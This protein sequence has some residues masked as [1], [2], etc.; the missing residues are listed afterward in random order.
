MAQAQG[1][2]DAQH[3]ATD[4]TQAQKETRMTKDEI[5]AT[6]G[7]VVLET[8]TVESLLDVILTYVLQDGTPLNYE[9]IAEVE[10]RHRRKTLGFFF[11]AMKERA[12]Y[13]EGLE[14]VFD[15]FLEARNTLIHRFREVDGHELSSAADLKK[16]EQFLAEL[17]Q[18]TQNLLKFFTAWIVAWQDQTGIGNGSLD[19]MMPKEGEDLLREINFMSHD[20]ENHVFK[21][22]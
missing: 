1:V 17:H 8:Q 11:K 19:T 12:D 3:A 9:R 6:I 16:V 18:D 4:S 15:R 22:K 10:K 20:V 2:L 7:V 13:S 21:K 5:F 14:D